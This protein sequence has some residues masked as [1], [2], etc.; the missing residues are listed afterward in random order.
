MTVG[1]EM[2]TASPTVGGAMGCGGAAAAGAAALA[3]VEPAGA[4]DGVGLLTQDAG[5]GLRR[6][7]RGQAQDYLLYAAVS[8][9]VLAVF[10]IT[11]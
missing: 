8:V 4:V 10:I 7:V 6:L 1:L 5:R 9:A 11:R 3:F 2:G